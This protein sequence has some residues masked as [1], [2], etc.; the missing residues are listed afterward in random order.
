MVL[1]GQL[2]TQPGKMILPLV[3]KLKKLCKLFS[4]EPGRGAPLCRERDDEHR[5]RQHRREGVDA[6]YRCGEPAEEAA[7]ALEEAVLLHDGVDA[8]SD[9]KLLGL[10]HRDRRW[11]AADPVEK[12]EELGEMQIDIGGSG[13]GLEHEI[14][15]QFCCQGGGTML[16]GTRR[17][18]ALWPGARGEHDDSALG[19]EAGGV[20]QMLIVFKST[21]AAAMPPLHLC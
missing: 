6:C 18:R 11:L 15:M 9:Y 17:L 2:N 3:E 21:S 5:Q 1:V 4:L 13:A 10:E 20:M 8:A 14:G 16:F 7:D 19:G 12:L